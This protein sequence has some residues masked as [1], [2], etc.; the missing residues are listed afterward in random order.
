MEMQKELRAFLNAEGRLTAWPA[1]RKKKLA[2]L[3]FLAEKFEAG[4]TYTEKEVNALLNAWHTY[5]DPATLRRELY[6]NGFLD[7]A[8]DGSAYRLADKQPTP[9]ELGLEQRC[10]CARSG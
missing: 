2:A 8:R 6:D 5:G 1:K 10:P 4:R 9:E 3:F 7:R